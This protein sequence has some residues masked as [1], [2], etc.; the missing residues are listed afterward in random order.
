MERSAALGLG[1]RMISSPVRA[2]QTECDDGFALSGLRV[3][4]NLN[5]GLHPALSHHA[6][7]GLRRRQT[8]GLVEPIPLGGSS[9]ELRLNL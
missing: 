4:L 9:G 3:L 2:A 6:L 8:V 5:P 1:V 7:A